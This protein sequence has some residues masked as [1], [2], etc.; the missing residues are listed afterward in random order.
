MICRFRELR[1]GLALGIRTMRIFRGWWR[2]KRELHVDRKLINQ[3]ICSVN[4]L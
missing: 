2:V 3:G 4:S 1:R